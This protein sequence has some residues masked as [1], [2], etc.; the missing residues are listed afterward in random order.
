MLT[1]THT[2]A[3]TYTH[4]YIHIHT[5]THT[6]TYTHTY[7]HNV[8]THI[9]ARTHTIAHILQKITCAHNTVEHI[10]LGPYERL[11][12]INASGLNAFQ[13]HAVWNLREIMSCLSLEVYLGEVC[14]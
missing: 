13:Q 10:L 7:T 14:I 3:H 11:L 6:N 8:Y 4:I 2:H 5:H 1:H 9:H 12:I